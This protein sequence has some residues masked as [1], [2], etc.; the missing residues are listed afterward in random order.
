MSL[1]TMSKR[2]KALLAALAGAALLVLTDG[3]PDA[4]SD[5]A[6][7]SDASGASGDTRV[8]AAAPRRA[9][10][11][12]APA[13]MPPVPDPVD[14]DAPIV[15]LFAAA[16][17]ATPAAS[18][19]H[20]AGAQP[21]QADGEGDAA[22]KLVLLGFR[23][24]DGV[25]EAYLMHNEDMVIARPGAVFGQRYRVLALKPDSVRLQDKQSGAAIELGF[26]QKQ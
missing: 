25:R 8:A 19:A 2:T 14:A 16:A 1:R 22:P 11:A 7:A 20:A 6:G 21:N 4:A 24:A 12:P 9:P 15:D 5:A 13:A 23:D 3:A 17:G 18:L 10:R 26:E